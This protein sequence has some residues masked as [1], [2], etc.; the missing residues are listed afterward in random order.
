M[1]P[2][3]GFSGEARARASAWIR[4]ERRAGRLPKP[5]E[6]GACGQREGQLDDHAEDYSEP[7]GPQTVQFPLCYR[8]HMMLHCRFT[9][10]EAFEAY[11]AAVATGIRFPAMHRRDFGVL[12]FQH[13][14][15]P[16]PTTD[17]EQVDDAMRFRPPVKDLLGELA[18]GIHDPRTRRTA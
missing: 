11:R 7:F 17:P 3:N 4:G 14:R 1:R 16:F 18:A 15:R 9:S 13:L 12:T 10:S 6:C 5:E 2:Y 8:C